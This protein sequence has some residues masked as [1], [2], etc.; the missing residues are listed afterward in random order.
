MERAK[1]AFEGT[2]AYEAGYK[3]GF[4]DYRHLVLKWIDAVLEDNPDYRIKDMRKIVEIIT[5]TQE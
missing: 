3:D 5:K 4:N 2:E 1:R